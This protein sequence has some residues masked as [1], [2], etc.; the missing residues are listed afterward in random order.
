VAIVAAIV[1]TLRR[2]PNLRT[3]S[4][5][6]QLEP[7]RNERLRLLRMPAEPRRPVGEE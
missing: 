4:P 7:E 2:R 3:P 6:K 5:S 1:L